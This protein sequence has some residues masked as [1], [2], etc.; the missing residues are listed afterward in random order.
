MEQFV[1]ADE[2][3][4]L[5]RGLRMIEDVMD[6]YEGV[7]WRRPAACKGFVRAEQGRDRAGHIREVTAS[8]R[9]DH[10]FEAERKV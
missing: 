3:D 8:Y 4:D 10:I 9:F 1:L 2:F 7:S 5:A 6:V